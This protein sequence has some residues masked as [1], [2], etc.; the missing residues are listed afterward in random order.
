M[1][2]LRN[3]VVIAAASALLAGCGSSSRKTSFDTEGLRAPEGS[4]EIKPSRIGLA[5]KIR[6][7][8]EGNGC[9]IPNAWRVRGLGSVHFSQPATMNC[10]MAAP[11]RDWL[12]DTV[13]PAAQ[14]S[15]GESVVSVDVA[16]SY[17]CRPRNGANGAKMS[18]HGFGNAIDITGFTLES[19]RKVTVLDGWR[20]GGEERRFLHTVHE[21]A[22]GEFRTVLGP[23][24]DRHHRDHL[25][26]DLQNRR[27]GSVYCR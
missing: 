26:L 10:G 13:Q 19:G 25:H 2:F 1:A 4:C 21:D 7:I 18:E 3:L 12:E 24:A 5:E 23:N 27:S 20:G 8:D 9:E 6:D 17:S 14:R 22:C 16:A 11:L 15:F